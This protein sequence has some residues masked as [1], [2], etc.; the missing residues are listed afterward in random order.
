MGGPGS[1]RKA[2]V[3]GTNKSQR[4]ILKNHA[5]K[6]GKLGQPSARERRLLENNLVRASK[7]K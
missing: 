7:R 2:G 5:K 4:K 3:L 1:G 6:F